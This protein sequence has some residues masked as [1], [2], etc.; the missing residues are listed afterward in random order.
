MYFSEALSQYSTALLSTLTRLWTGA[1]VNKGE[2]YL[3][4]YYA[5]DPSTYDEVYPKNPNEHVKEIAGL[6]TELIQLL[7][8]MRYLDETQVAFPPHKDRPIDRKY[9]A[10]FG[11]TKNVVD[12]YQMI[13]YVNGPPNW[14]HGSDA[15]EFVG[16]GEF[17]EDLRQTPF[18]EERD[19]VW[20]ATW[21]Q[22]VIDPCYGIDWRNFRDDPDRV[23][24]IN[25]SMDWDAEDGPYIR[26]WYAVLSSIGNHGSFLCLNTKNC[27]L[28]RRI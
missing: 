18:H 2:A 20:Q 23:A 6:F 15:G 17:L 28:Y 19:A 7:I 24:K 21:E 5:V 3:G 9:P 16:G 1:N 27:K 25:T 4:V 8:D 22:A 13:P 14:N 12:M 10:R 26:P 11:L